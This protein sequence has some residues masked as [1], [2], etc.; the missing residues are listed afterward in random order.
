MIFFEQNTH[1][2]APQPLRT[3][4]MASSSGFRVLDSLAIRIVRRG[5]EPF[6]AARNSLGPTGYSLIKEINRHCQVAQFAGNAHRAEP[7]PLFAQR[8]R[9]SPLN[10][11]NDY[12]VLVLGKKVLKKA[13]ESGDERPRLRAS[14]R[15]PHTFLFHFYVCSPC[16]LDGMW[17]EGIPVI[18]TI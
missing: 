13:K 1:K 6:E 9:P 8:A 3:Y 10:C 7:S 11:K 2:S 14:Q 18:S 5:R 17:A 15:I 12:L 4:H 16:V